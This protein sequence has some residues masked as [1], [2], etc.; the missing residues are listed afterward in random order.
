[1]SRAG[2]P[3][4]AGV[5]IVRDPLGGIEPHGE[6]PPKLAASPD[7]ALYA[8]YTVGKEVVGSRFPK[9]ALRFVRS[10]DQGTSWSEP[11]SVNEGERFGSH[12][13]HA[14]LAGP[15]GV[16]FAAWLSST[17]GKSGVWL[18]RSQDGGVT[19][20]PARSIDTGEAC[21]C[22]RT[23]LALGPD[24]S[25]FISWRKV[26]D[27][28]IRDVVVMRSRDGGESWDPPVRPREDGWVFAGCPHAGPA[29]A[30]DRSGAVHIAWWTGK[31]GEAGVYYAKSTDGGETFRAV[32]IAVS[33][34]AAPAHVQVA[35]GDFGAVV[36]W[37]DGLSRTPRVLIRSIDD[38]GRLGREIQVSGKG[39]ASFPVLGVRG[40]SVQIAWT[41]QEEAAHHAEAAARPDMKDPKA[42]MK[43]PRVGQSEI[44]ARRVK[45]AEL[46]MAN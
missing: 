23:G 11:I 5:A 7:G 33:S 8:L 9:S 30:V 38:R 22:C 24:G 25:L 44:F 19:W 29:L 46:F 28:S 14:L 15:G 27:G 43:L 20:G 6:A 17:A 13:F 26:F 39:A 31:E 3:A 40:D 1:V 2:A 42:V 4:P 35:A 41:Q 21:P 18:R 32:P 37:D 36:A 45:V 16:V 34:R 12:N 10:L